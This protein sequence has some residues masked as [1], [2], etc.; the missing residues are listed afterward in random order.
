[1]KKTL[2]L[3]PVFF[4]FLACKKEQPEI[5]YRDKYVGDYTFEIIHNYPIITRVD[6][7][8]TSILI[9]H[10][11]TSF[12]SGYIKKSTS[13]KNRVLVHWGTDTL[14]IIKNIAYT[15]TN[16]I[17]VDS[18]GLLSYPEYSGGGHTFFY[19]PAFLRND[20]ASFNFGR[21]GLGAWVNWNVKGLKKK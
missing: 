12:Y 2:I 20:S 9:W 18:V 1:M 10:D 21:G 17:V 11:S 13:S 16:E 6:S 5:D 4:C 7:L 19:P 14:G 3:L 15:Q 8:Q